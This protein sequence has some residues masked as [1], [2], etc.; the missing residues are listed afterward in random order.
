MARCRNGVSL[1]FK[2]TEGFGNGSGKTLLYQAAQ[3]LQKQGV[4]KIQEKKMGQCEPLLLWSPFG[5]AERSWVEG[6]EG[7]D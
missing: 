2:V 3:V 4:I 1:D 7:A 6:V 5:G